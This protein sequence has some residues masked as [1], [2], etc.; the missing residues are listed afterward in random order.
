MEIS[1]IFDRILYSEVK[2]KSSLK[3]YLLRCTKKCEHKQCFLKSGHWID[4]EIDQFCLNYLHSGLF[5]FKAN[6][7]H[8]TLNKLENLL[9]D[10]LLLW[11][12]LLIFSIEHFILKL[13]F[14]YFVCAPK[15]Y[16]WAE[17]KVWHLENTLNFAVLMN[18]LEQVRYLH[19][20]HLPRRDYV[21]FI[22]PYVLGKV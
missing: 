18:F 4:G 9:Q 6:V 1:C 20:H 17:S 2:E 22:T 14:F 7:L 8:Q 12:K 19:L 16:F 3:R 21:N 13:S 10:F 15:N 11:L 5:L